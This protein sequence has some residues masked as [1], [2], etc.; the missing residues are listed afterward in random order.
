MV[1]AIC[2]DKRFGSESALAVGHRKNWSLGPWGPHQSGPA[3]EGWRGLVMEV[4]GITLE[5]DRPTA[6][7]REG[8]REHP[9]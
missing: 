7:P 9:A 8:G 1:H 3:L 5:G 4:N 6:K 2:L